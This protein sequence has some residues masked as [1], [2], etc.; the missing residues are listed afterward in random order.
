MQSQV[1]KQFMPAGRLPV[2][3]HTVNRF[4][5]AS[6]EIKIIL[7]LPE[8]DIFTWNELCT[9]YNFA[10][11]HAKV[12][13]GETRFHSVRNGLQAIAETDG[14][15][16]IHDGV[17][18]FVPVETIK[19]SYA[20]AGE[21]GCA[22]A[23]VPLKDSIRKINP[24]GDSYTVSRTDFRL[25]QTPQ[26]FRLSVIKQSFSQ[27]PHTDFTDDASV[28]EAAGFSISL[29]EGSYENIKITTPEDLLW[30]E[31]FLKNKEENV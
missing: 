13:G 12:P 26:T 1:P 18:P 10:I 7:V 19:R 23:A 29:I 6:P 11:P 22:I 28:A 5:L 20:V 8:K 15:V 16:A 31:A 9:A 3:M 25:V 4:Y 14:L 2:L 24:E 21:K 30:A 17:R 27:A